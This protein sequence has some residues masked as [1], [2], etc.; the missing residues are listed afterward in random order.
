MPSIR[1]NF[2]ASIGI[3]VQIIVI[4]KALKAEAGTE[5]DAKDVFP[6]GVVRPF[7]ATQNQA[8]R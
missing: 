5:L 6:G 3:V 8:P 7:K 1:G 2:E 4:P